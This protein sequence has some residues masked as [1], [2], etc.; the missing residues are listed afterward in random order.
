MKQNQ[1]ELLEM[2]NT[3]KQIKNSM[4]S[5]DNRMSEAPDRIWDLSHLLFL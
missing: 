2:K 1:I 3:I 5:L 4:E